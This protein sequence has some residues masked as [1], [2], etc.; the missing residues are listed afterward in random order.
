MADASECHWRHA[1]QRW[2]RIDDATSWWTGQN[3]LTVPQPNELEQLQCEVARQLAEWQ[4]CATLHL[5]AY[6]RAA[7]RCQSWDARLGG[8]AGFISAI[9][10]TAAAGSEGA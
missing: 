1:A 6:N 2:A 7:N 3:G 9:V 4:R 10:G 8:F 5:V